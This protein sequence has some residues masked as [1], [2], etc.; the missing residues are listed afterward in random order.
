[1]NI[2]II[3]KLGDAQGLAQRMAFEGHHVAMWIK[4]PAY[5]H[6]GFGIVERPESW[7]EKL[8]WCDFI[9]VD[10][11]G[12]GSFEKTFKTFGKPYIACSPAMDKLELD[13]AEGMRLFAE[14]GIEVPETWSFSSAEKAHGFFVGLDWG[15]GFVVKADGNLGCATTRLV[16]DPDQLEWV[17]DQYKA[18]TSI[19]VQRIIKGVE[20][21]TEGWFN[22]R[23]FIKPFNHTFE[24]KRFMEGNLGPNTGCAGNVVIARESN[25][26]TKATVERMKPF[27]VRAGYRGPLDVNCIV[28]AKGAFALE[29][30]AR[31][32]YDAIE[33]LL[34]GVRGGVGDFFQEIALGRMEKMEISPDYLIG[35][36][37]TVPPY[38]T[39]APGLKGVWGEPIL[40]VNENNISHL[41]L[42][43]V[44]LNKE[45]KFFKT[46]G[47]D[48]L[49]L[50]ATARG[51]DVAMARRRVY[52]TLDNIRVGD[53]QYRRDIGLRVEGDIK[54]LEEW[55]WL[56]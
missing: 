49:T 56:K 8:R 15:E 23:D 5:K 33:A 22:G 47:A 48:G 6:S 44:C 29:A 11:V 4:D 39:E 18:A 46:G 51:E 14:V 37:L 43:D 40:G 19:I 35:V 24:E 41:W 20:V 52:R 38:P 3:S 55:G 50:V 12:V 45:D 1:M 53:K 2:L 34:E 42:C 7:R 31:L 36:R 32:G 26:L 27:L 17:F 30:T 25:R 16:K 21:S 28:N 9:L 54:Q 13:R 10:M